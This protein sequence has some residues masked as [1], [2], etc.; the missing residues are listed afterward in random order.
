MGIFKNFAGAQNG[1]VFKIVPDYVDKKRVPGDSVIP[2]VTFLDWLKA[3][4]FVLWS[5]PNTVWAVVSLIMYF[6]VPYDLSPTSAAAAS[7]LSWAFFKLRFPLWFAVTY[8]Y[9][10]FWH[11]TLYFLGWAERPFIRNRVYNT[12]KVVHNM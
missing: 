2:A 7:P 9:T 3:S 10:A 5:S 1:R 11:V 6:A 12:D 4:P 8:G